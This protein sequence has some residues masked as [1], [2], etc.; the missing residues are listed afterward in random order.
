MSDMCKNSLT[1]S[2]YRP[3]VD[4]TWNGL[5]TLVVKFNLYGIYF[6]NY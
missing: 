3:L 6:S 5:T 1:I 4:L 2:S